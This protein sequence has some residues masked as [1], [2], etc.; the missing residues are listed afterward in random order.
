LKNVCTEKKTKTKTKTTTTTTTTLMLWA[1]NCFLIGISNMFIINKYCGYNTYILHK[2][3]LF[4]SYNCL[5]KLINQL[6]NIIN[7]LQKVNN[8]SFKT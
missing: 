1:I 5:I 7:K 4:K 6:K 8:S 3:N 2:M